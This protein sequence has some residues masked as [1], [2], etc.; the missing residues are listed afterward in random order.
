MIIITRVWLNG[1]LVK[2]KLGEGWA[3]D[4]EQFFPVTLKQGKNVLLVAIHC[5][6]GGWAGH[7]G[8]AP[9]AE[10]TVVSQDPGF[11]LSTEPAQLR[12]E[13]PSPSVSMQRTS[14]I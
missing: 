5:W 6:G 11:T 4:Y 8:F 7:F 14:P 10:Y 13:T 12:K 2:E 9:D 1:A 3:H